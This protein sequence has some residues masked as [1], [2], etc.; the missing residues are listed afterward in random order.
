[1]RVVV[2]WIHRES[3]DRLMHNESDITEIPRTWAI[4]GRTV[5]WQPDIAPNERQVRSTVGRGR[6]W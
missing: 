6:R 3:G 2:L 5:V 1:M 4:R